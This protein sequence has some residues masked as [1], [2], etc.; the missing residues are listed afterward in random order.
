MFTTPCFIRKCTLELIAQLKKLGYSLAPMMTLDYNDCTILL[1]KNVYIPLSVELSSD[2][3]EYGI[4]CGVNS[5]LFLAIAAL[6][7]DTDE[8]QYFVHS[9]D[10]REEDDELHLIKC[11]SSEWDFDFYSWNSNDDDF[12]Y[13]Y[14]KATVEELREYFNPDEDVWFH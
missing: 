12:S 4:D 11:E 8:H 5:K 13:M 3:T 2:N 7:D 9:E 14:R 1:Q 10:Y 6:R